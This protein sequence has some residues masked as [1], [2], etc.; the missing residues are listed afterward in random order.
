MDTILTT[1]QSTIMG[2]HGV[3]AHGRHMELTENSYIGRAWQ[4]VMHFIPWSKIKG[5]YLV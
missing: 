2:Q 5:N 3:L 1:P 4:S